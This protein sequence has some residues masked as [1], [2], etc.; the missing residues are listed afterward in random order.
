MVTLQEKVWRLW[1]MGLLLLLLSIP[2][3]VWAQEALPERAA[4]EQNLET[5]SAIEQPDTDQQE[6]IETLRATL[7]ALEDLESTREERNELEQ[8]IERAPEERQRLESESRDV[9][10]EEVPSAESLEKIDLNELESRVAE[11]LDRLQSLQDELAKT[12]SRL[13][14]AQTLPERAQASISEALESIEEKRAAL[15]DYSG[16]EDAPMA[17][18]LRSELALAESRLALKRRELAANTQLFE[19]AKQRRELLVRQIDKVED[20][21]SLLQTVLDQKR[22]D[23]L[24]NTFNESNDEGALPAEG[25]PVVDQIRQRNRELNLEMLQVIDRANALE[26][27]AIKVRTQLD[28]VRQVQRTLKEQIEAVRGSQLLS[29]ILR[30]QRRSLPRVDTVK[31]LQERIADI[32]LKQFELSRQ[33]EG[34][35]DID[36]LA[37]EQ[38]AEAGLEASPA[39]IDSLVELYRSRRDLIDQLEREYGELLTTAI[40]LQLNQQQLLEISASLRLTIEEQL[41]WVANRR[42]L[43]LAWLR[44]L[45]ESLAA[46]L[47]GDGWHQKLDDFW[48]SPRPGGLWALPLLL[49][50]L[51]LSLRRWRIKARLQV[52]HDQV[53]RLKRDT[54]MHTPWAILLNAMIA[55][56]G[57]LSMAGVGIALTQGGQGVAIAWGEALLQLSLTWGV[58]ALARRLLVSDGVAVRHFHWPAAY[59]TRLRRLLW[60]LGWALVPVLLISSLAQ[61]DGPSLAERPIFLLL[62]LAGLVAMSL[63][64]AR[65]IL[66]H[67]P[68]F[69][70]KLFRLL[71][72]LALA[73]ATL[74]LGVL[75]VLGYEYTALQLVSRFIASLYIFGLWILVE[76]S[77]VRGLAVAARR[78]AYRRAVARRR[79]QVQEG[80]EGGLEVVEEPPLDLDQVNQQSLRLSK[81]ILFLGFSLVLYLLWAD[82]LTVLAYLDNVGIWSI[83]QGVGESLSETPI[84][85]ADLLTALVTV[86]LM[87]VMARNLPGLLEVMVLSRLSLQHGSAYAISS[88]LSYTIVAAGVV[89]ALGTLGVSWSKLQWLVAALGVGLGFGLQEIFANFISG[90]IILFERP[91]R[92]GDTITLGN[93]HGTV[94][95]IRIRATTMTDFDRKEIIIPNK[96]FVTDQLV[97]WSLSDNVTR[98]I[99]T[100][101]VAHGSDLDTVHRLL[102]QAADENSRVLKDPEPQVLCTSYG[103]SAFN[104]ELRIFVNDLLDRLFAADE[105]N[106]RLDTLFRDHGIRIAFNQMDVWLHDADGRAKNVISQAEG[107]TLGE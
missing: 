15:D 8:Q 69:G 87:F 70:V 85:V 57:P 79:A 2:M 56:P 76:A 7:D 106:R 30:E 104:F 96:T 36:Q 4:I 10:E 11:T 35:R 68:Y 84:T 66:A 21:L 50:A 61:G 72:G 54:Q 99:L 67:T 25:N 102:G 3:P 44:Q 105:I 16:V 71:L 63:L 103:P 1:L 62:I 23:R 6:E 52:L 58:V 59:A 73:G 100:Y 49:L 92:I 82:L 28:R 17:W 94:S 12:N 46:Q 51:G 37:G 38:V 27:E 64:L 101:G 45:P 26:R 24:E 93:L 14:A 48:Q 90:L 91:I 33:R 40:D 60:W 18:L 81:L 97:N 89:A 77:V 34:L 22:R 39:L 43:D 83:T 55:A 74:V 47:S 32:R 20:R 88:L 80:A 9:A 75:I 19:L 107:K 65:L 78:L 41:F 98:V 5:L 53:G 31:G 86:V 42:P 13:I 95:R 29:R